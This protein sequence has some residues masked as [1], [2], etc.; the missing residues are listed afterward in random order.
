MGILVHEAELV[1]HATGPYMVRNIA[2]SRKSKK[3]Q[4]IEGVD[5]EGMPRVSLYLLLAVDCL[6]IITYNIR[7][8]HVEKR[9][10]CLGGSILTS[11]P[12]SCRPLMTEMIKG[13]RKEVEKYFKKLSKKFLEK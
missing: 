7:H 5:I 4:F 6:Y 8:S 1:S 3:I 11:N 13:E 9:T 12:S 2:F 10:A